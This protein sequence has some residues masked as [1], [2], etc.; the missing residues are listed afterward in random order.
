MFLIPWLIPLQDD[1]EKFL[2][3]PDIPTTVKLND[4]AKDPESPSLR[5]DS[6]IFYDELVGNVD[7]AKTRLLRSEPSRES[8]PNSF[9]LFSIVP[10]DSY[11]DLSVGLERRENSRSTTTLTLHRPS[12][13]THNE[14]VGCDAR[15]AS[16][17]NELCQSNDTGTPS[18]LVQNVKQSMPDIC[19]ML[20]E[21]TTDETPDMATKIQA[22][23]LEVEAVEAFASSYTDNSYSGPPIDISHGEM[24]VAEQ[25]PEH[26]RLRCASC[27]SSDS[28]ISWKSASQAS[29]GTNDS[30]YVEGIMPSY[31]S[32]DFEQNLDPKARPEDKASM[33]TTEACKCGLKEERMD[34]TMT[35]HG[36]TQELK[37][38]NS[39]FDCY[40][41]MLAD[42]IDP[43]PNKDYYSDVME[44]KLEESTCACAEEGEH[45]VHSSDAL[46]SA[47]RDSNS[48]SKVGMTEAPDIFSQAVEK[49][50]EEAH[51]LEQDLLNRQV[52]LL[53][54]NRTS[55]P[56]G[57]SLC[58]SHL[59]LYLSLSS[60]TIV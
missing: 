3:L 21:L 58:S 12:P 56:C 27:N 20:P 60:E 4:E 50:L 15:M 11:R 43:G 52:Q 54:R 44:S 18:R 14:G 59:E 26:E 7:L 34:S 46:V 5:V 31:P 28:D 47:S 53:R 40:E 25:D 8:R 57:A 2:L 13:L 36:S 39:T 45:A 33:F 19:V 23:A 32:G 17:V 41:N 22:A 9:I 24:G 55:S 16:S 37:I 49:L 29:D 35:R 10:R 1:T 6:T 48:L 42:A 30:G 51:E 38:T